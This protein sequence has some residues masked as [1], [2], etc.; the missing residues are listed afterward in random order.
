MKTVIIGFYS[1][2]NMTVLKFCNPKQNCIDIYGFTQLLHI[3]RMQHK[4][5]FL[6]GF[7]RFEF[8]VFLLQDW[9][10]SSVCPTIYT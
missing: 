5:T 10:M 8:R 9:L 7:N 3:S 2:P 1:L 6:K 4:V